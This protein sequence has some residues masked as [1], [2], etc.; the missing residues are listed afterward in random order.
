MKS[1]LYR[2][3]ARRRGLAVAALVALA[4]LPLLLQAIGQDFYVSFAARLL[5]FALAATGLNFIVGFGG[6]VAF[7]HAAFFGAGA[8]TVAI[9][10]QHGVTSAFV[11]W[12][13]AA[14]LAALLALGIG[15]VS[16]RT[17]GVYF[18]MITL[19]FAQMIYYLFISLKTWGGDDG[20]SLPARSGF[21]PLHLGDDA[22]FYWVVLACLAAV[23]FL[24]D[25]IAH[26]RFGRVLQ[27]IREN[28]SRME[29]L[30]YPVAAYQLACFVI[31][32]TLAGL[33]GALIANHGLLASPNLLHWT[34]SGTLLV[35]VIVGGVGA[36]YGGFAGALTLLLLEEALAAVTGH[37]HVALGLLLLG[38]VFYAPRGVAAYLHG[39]VTR[40]QN[41]D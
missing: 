39:L 25:R 20:L 33:A 22:V 34:Q 8:Y 16:L 35:M 27:A 3:S 21:G 18:I 10:A 24:L 37:W 1:A 26:A 15:A 19:A 12:P 40:R 17:R 14:G 4:A 9:L 38:V 2:Q 6:M 7:G 5:I 29:A 13:A 31:G 28:E 23:L 30:G 32:G 41:D 36:L 11:A